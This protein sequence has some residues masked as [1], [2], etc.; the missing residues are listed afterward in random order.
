M[1]AG[2]VGGVGGDAGMSAD[3]NSMRL[4]T[5]RAMYSTGGLAVGNNPGSKNC[6]DRPS[7]HNHLYSTT[8]A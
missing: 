2:G 5:R 6:L 8:Q 1:D 7:C 4:D 3:R